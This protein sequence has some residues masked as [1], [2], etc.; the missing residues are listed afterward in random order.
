MKPLAILDVAKRYIRRGWAI[1]PVPHQ[2]KNPGFRGWQKLRLSEADLAE[3]FNG[4][5]QNIGVLLGEPSGW[6]IDIDIDHKRAV[7][8]AEQYLPPT[9]SVFGR[10]G[11]TRSHW[12]YKVTEPVETKRHKSKSADM[13]VELRSTGTQTVFPP[14]THESGESISWEDE[15]AEPALVDP[16]ELL[17]AV[18]NLATAVLVELGEKTPTRKTT[19]PQRTTPPPE[20]VKLDAGQRSQNCIA[21]ML[22]MRMTD[23]ND[24]SGRLYA[25]AC[26]TV[27]HDL[28]DADAVTAIRSYEAQRQF[29]R[30]WTDTEILQR[31]RDAEKECKRGKEM[32]RLVGQADEQK[33]DGYQK[34]DSS[35][36]DPMTEARSFLEVYDKH[37][38]K[39]KLRCW[40]NGFWAWDGKRYQEIP[41]PDI[42]AAIVT[43]VDQKAF[44]I[45]SGVINNVIECLKSISLILFNV[46]QPSWLGKGKH[47][48]IAMQNGLL[49]AEKAIAGE[50][51]CFPHTPLWFSAVALD[52]G[53]D[54]QA[55]CPKW[56]A[57]LER[58]L[59]ADPQRISILQEFF[60]YCFQPDTSYHKFLL[61]VGE[62]Q[63]GK[64]VACSVLESL[65]GKDNVSN[66][67]LEL[68]GMRFQLNDTQGK[69]AAR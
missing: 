29:P 34:I 17:D 67:P 25:A 13:V 14:S 64:S 53:F 65:L 27:E 59:E 46:E 24:G 35:K 30:D 57:F 49:D 56:L 44:G 4:K 41:E 15:S 32:Q 23:T 21:A 5:P 63:N 7:E 8:L 9:P 28:T 54:P 16:Q 12:I 50:S 52:Y 6:L 37:Q 45:R 1:I 31:V 40:K 10:A 38:D 36:L 61:I 26:R 3:R 48:Y 51:D 58:N 42:R 33:T 11:N 66:V 2:S 22:R 60:G 47:R 20:A 62:G 39:L 19:A 55:E 68:F 69:L 18:Q 43:H